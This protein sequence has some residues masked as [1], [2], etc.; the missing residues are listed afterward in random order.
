MDVKA[1][2]HK[3]IKQTESLGQE[4][5][6]TT[7]QMHLVSPSG[8]CLTLKPHVYD[9]VTTFLKWRSKDAAHAAPH[10]LKSNQR[11]THIVNIDLPQG[12]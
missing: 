1:F 10:G 2:T 9:L 4:E 5:S 6:R 3:M 11:V 12:G 8:D 7:G